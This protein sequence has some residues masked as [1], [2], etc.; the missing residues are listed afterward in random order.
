MRTSIIAGHDISRIIPFSVIGAFVLVAGIACAG[1]HVLPVRSLRLLSYLLPAMIGLTAILVWQ[2]KLTV[3]LI[4]ISV[5]FSSD[6]VLAQIP[7]RNVNLRAED[8]ILV[9]ALLVLIIRY[10]AGREK[11]IGSESHTPL[12]RPI[13]AYCSVA[14]LSTLLGIYL[15]DVSPLRGFFFF[16]K[17]VEYFIFF[18][19]IC[20]YLE[21]KKEIKVAI[22]LIFICALVLSINDVYMRLTG[23]SQWRAFTLTVDAERVTEYGEI[24]VLIIPLAVAIA[25]ES[26]SFMVIAIA[27]FAVLVMLY[28]LLDTLRRSAFVGVAAAFLFLAIYKYRVLLPLL[29][30]AALYFRARL[31]E[32]VAERVSF[33]WTEITQFP[34]PGGSLIERVMGVKTAVSDWLYRPLL[35]RGLATYSLQDPVSHNQYAQMILETGLLGLACF[36]WLVVSI[37]KLCWKGAKD[38]PVLERSEGT[39]FASSETEDR[40]YRGFCIGFLAGILGWMVMCLGTISFTSIRTMNCFMIVTAILVAFDSSSQM[41]G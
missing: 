23:A 9:V 29:A 33:L 27:P 24:L 28:F 41:A 3:P 30:G 21:G 12:D 38:A 39:D 34:Y 15:G 10:A 4:I 5:F 16:A 7:G 36:L 22:Y 25:I 11:I 35:G 19:L 20:H 32:N 6:I 17:R 2:P 14:L 31:P 18:Y 37:A 13:L 40:L 26:R 1:F 8:G